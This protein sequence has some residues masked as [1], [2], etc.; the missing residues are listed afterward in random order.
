[1]VIGPGDQVNAAKYP[2]GWE[3]L[4][5]D[6]QNGLH[7]ILSQTLIQRVMEL[8]TSGLLSRARFH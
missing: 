1:M 6:D 5:F 8:I 7:P 3:Q 4:K 2:W